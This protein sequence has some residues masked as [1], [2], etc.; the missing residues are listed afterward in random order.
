[1]NIKK[2]LAIALL[3]IAALSASAQMPVEITGHLIKKRL[4]PVKLFKVVEGKAVEISSIAPTEKGN[5]GFL[6]YPEYE[7]LYVVGTGTVGSPND[8]YKFYFKSGDKLAVNLLDSSYV[9]TGKLNSKENIVLTQWHDL[10]FPLEMKAV[11]FMKVQSTFV[12]YFPL[13]EEI[14]TKTKSFLIGKATGNAK[15]DKNIQQ[16]M[17]WDLAS[18]ATNFLNTPRSA[19]PAVEEYS[20]YYATLKTQDFAKNTT[21]IYANPW[22]K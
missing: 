9:L 4:S 12:D 14:V 19:H 2:T 20:P 17:K 8:N 5:F 18:Y 7:G 10:V 21:E 1:M 22:G 16:Y 3:S 11:N 15:F 6:F 13:Q